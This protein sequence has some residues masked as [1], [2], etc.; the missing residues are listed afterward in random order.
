MLKSAHPELGGPGPFHVLPLMLEPDPAR[1]VLR[2]FDFAYPTAFAGD[3]EDRRLV[4]ARRVLDLE[5][6]EQDRLV[7]RMLEAMHE[8]HRNAEAVF[9]RRYAELGDNIRRLAA[10]ETQKLLLGAYFSQEFAFESA[11]LFNPT[12][13]PDPRDTDEDG[14]DRFVLALRG[15]GEGHISS[16][17]FRTG[18][19]NA[20]G[21][22]TVDPP[23][24]YA[25]PPRIIRDM[26]GGGAEL[27]CEDSAD[28]S[29]T[30]IFP[31]LP[32]QSHGV[33]D[34]RLV[35][36]TEDDGQRLIIG[37]YTAFDGRDARQELLRGIDFRTVQMHPL[38]GRMAAYKGMALFPRRIG[39]R[40]VM[41][42]RQDNENIW[43]L[44]SDDLYRWDDGRPIMCPE[45]FWEF[46]QL[47][48]CGSPIEID[49]GWLVFTHGVAMV[50]AYS[51]GACLLD[52]DDPSI[53]LARTPRPLLIPS[54]SERGGYVPNVVY[55][56]GALVRDRD[57]LLP[58]AVGDRCTAFA[59]GTV[60]S[61]LAAMV[62][63][64]VNEL[65]HA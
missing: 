53:V 62:E 38:T 50:R 35:R 7:G 13:V 51:I 8:R 65:A 54:L 2:P 56:C 46:V 11:A 32:S 44:E 21:C 58:Y 36:F 47:G 57:V 63:C 52:K 45:Y 15:V 3:R 29:E 9:L 39:G 6:A 48:N 4:V 10:N 41:L 42:G 23:S 40:Y 27:I 30:V 28:V 37:T 61:V 14:N 26:V 17:T 18:S 20:D 34:L 59:T 60:D 25:V 5:E 33:E 55:S 22:V 49:E 31:I 24:P 19:W 16:V 64:E 12:I 1:T 43:L